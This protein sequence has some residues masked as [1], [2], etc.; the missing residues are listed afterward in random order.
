MLNIKGRLIQLNML[1]FGVFYLVTAFFPSPLFRI[2]TALFLVAIVCQSLPAAKPINKYISSVLFLL[3]GMLLVQSGASFDDWV[4]AIGANSGMV[5]LFIVMPMLSFPLAYDDYEIVLRHLSVRY[6]NNVLRIGSIYTLITMFLGTILNIGAIQI[7]YD[8][9]PKGS[10]VSGVEKT[11][12]L[13]IVRGMSAANFLAPNYISMAVVLYYLEIPLTSVLPRGLVFS[14]VIILVHWLTVKWKYRLGGIA[15]FTIPAAQIATPPPLLKTVKLTM[16]F[17]GLLVMTV[18]VNIFTKLNILVIIPIIALSYPLALA[19]ILGRTAE[20]RD[21]IRRYLPSLATLN[22]QVS[23][24]AAA[25]FIG[26]VLEISGVGQM[27]PALLRLDIINTPSL[28]VL[29]IILLAILFAICGVHSIV[30]V[31]ALAASVSSADVGVSVLAYAYALLAAYSMAVLLSPF[32]GT[33]LIVSGLTQRTP[34]DVSLRSNWLYCL[35]M[36]AFFALVIPF[37]P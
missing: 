11:L 34:W 16:S 5:M 37:I 26:K 18:L 28:A 15:L 23:I 13:S 4:T 33:S 20:Y 14:L 31:T 36:I 8:L 27:I 3:G 1:F 29:V 10:K 24:F 22:N 17:L 9:F 19:V 2:L 6:I 12:H 32:S 25:G 21:E 30:T 7:V 35:I